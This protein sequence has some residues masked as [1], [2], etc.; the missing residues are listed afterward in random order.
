MGTSSSKMEKIEKATG[1]KVVNLRYLMKWNISVS[2]TARVMKFSGAAFFFSW[3]RH[4]GPIWDVIV[5]V[6][7]VFGSPR[8]GKS[9]KNPLTL[10][11]RRVQNKGFFELNSKNFARHI[12][13]MLTDILWVS[14]FQVSRTHI[15]ADKCKLIYFSVPNIILSSTI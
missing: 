1:S 13:W 11:R 3:N 9:E 14:W 12:V 5:V 4:F 8:I 2:V 10:D 6:K 7:N 15:Q